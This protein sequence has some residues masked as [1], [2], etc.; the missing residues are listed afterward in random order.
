MNVASKQS[1][2]AAKGGDR[3]TGLKEDFSRDNDL[4]T[5][6]MRGAG[7]H[8]HKTKKG[9]HA[10]A[11]CISISGFGCLGGFSGVTTPFFFFQVRM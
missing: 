2:S 4:L 10:I 8:V 7:G 6:S 3:S 11:S 5:F 1:L 9:H